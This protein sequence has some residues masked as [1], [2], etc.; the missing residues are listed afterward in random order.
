MLDVSTFATQRLTDGRAALLLA[1]GFGAGVFNGVAGGG[2]LISF[3]ALLALGYPA[4]TANMSSTVGIW[5]GY[6]GS[7]AGFRPEIADQRRHLRVLAPLTVLGAVVGAALLL[8]TPSHAFSR[9][10]PWLVLFASLLF[11]LRP[12]LA[13]G[14]ARLGHADG[15]VHRPILFVGMFLAAVYGGYF[16]AAMGVIMLAVLGLALPDTL[17]RSNGLRALLSVLANGV[18]ALVFVVHGALPWAAVGA[19]ALG[20]LVGG[21]AG[22]VLARRLPVPVMRVVIVCIGLATGIRLLVG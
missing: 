5:P 3:P 15:Q 16:G 4:L 11:V 21:Y 6:L 9:I 2:T 20:C 8:T 10:A 17:A 22:A 13:K 18:A 19:L 1:A 7:V 14:L 12:L